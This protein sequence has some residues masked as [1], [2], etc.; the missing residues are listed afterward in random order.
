MNLVRKELSELQKKIDANR[1]MVL[2]VMKEEGRSYEG[3]QISRQ[4]A[5]SFVPFFDIQ[6]K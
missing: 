6:K 1:K 5:G 3:K 4:I 2:E